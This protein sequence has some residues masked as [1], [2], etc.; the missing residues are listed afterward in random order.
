MACAESNKE[1]ADCYAGCATGMTHVNAKETVD[2]DGAVDLDVLD[3]LDEN[4]HDNVYLLILD[5]EENP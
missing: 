2:M 3:I 1:Y 4:D 5:S